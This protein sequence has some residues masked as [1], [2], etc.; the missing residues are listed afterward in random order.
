[1]KKLLALLL[2]AILMISPAACASDDD[3][4]TD[5]DEEKSSSSSQSKESSESE[6]ESNDESKGDFT[7]V[8]P[9]SNE[10]YIEDEIG[11]PGNNVEVPDRPVED[12]EEDVY[13]EITDEIVIEDDGPVEDSEE[14]IVIEDD[15]ENYFY[16][17]ENNIITPNEI[18]IRPAYAYWENGTLYVQCFVINGFSYSVHNLTVNSLKVSN[19]NCVL[20]EGAFGAMNGV[21]LNSNEHVLWTFEFSGDCVKNYGEDLTNNL[22]CSSNIGYYY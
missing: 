17:E 21:V 16:N 11:R 15:A 18:S 5:D 12:S 22:E 9:D 19:D 2:A 13:V 20:A 1:M 14:E 6:D 7:P 4:D 8:I 3:T 10:A